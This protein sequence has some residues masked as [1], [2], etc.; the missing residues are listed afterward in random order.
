[1]TQTV[2]QSVNDGSNETTVDEKDSGDT[3]SR[4]EIFHILRNRRRR[5]AIH[6][7]KQHDGSVSI[8]ELADQVTAWEHG[9]TPE[10]ITSQQRKRIYNSLQQTHLPKLARTGFVEYDSAR[11]T[12]E[13]KERAVRLDMYLE[14]VPERDLPW[15]QYYL[16]LG[17]VSVTLMGAVWLEA[18]PFSLLP[19]VVWGRTSRVYFCSPASHT[20][21]RSG[22]LD[23][24]RAMTHRKWSD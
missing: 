24:E 5:Y 12:V 7:L 13:L 17:G 1:M 9:I 3:V 19:S 11:G 20:C 23:S 4:D 6:Y 2:L 18:F 22:R 8:G 10:A 16:G 21:T 15:A 14:I